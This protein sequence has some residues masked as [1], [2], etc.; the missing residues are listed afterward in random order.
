MRGVKQERQPVAVPEEVAVPVDEVRPKHRPSRF[1][2]AWLIADYFFDASIESVQENFAVVRKEL[3]LFLGAAL[4]IFGVFGFE[5]GKYCDGN[6]ADYL[7]CTRPSTYYFYD[8]LDITCLI[9][10]VTLLLLW[11]LKRRT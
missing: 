5:S 10:G 7:S 6:T 9:V 1:R 3:Q 4:V 11:Y 2:L 8:A